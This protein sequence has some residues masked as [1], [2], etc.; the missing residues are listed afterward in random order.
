M[1]QLDKKSKNNLLIKIIL[2][3]RLL[4]GKIFIQNL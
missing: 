2:I 4:E 3:N 1:C